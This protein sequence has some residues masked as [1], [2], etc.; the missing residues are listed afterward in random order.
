M[1]SNEQLATTASLELLCACG[2]WNSTLWSVRR[3]AD[4]L[5]ANLVLDVNTGVKKHRDCKLYINVEFFFF[6]SRH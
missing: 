1:G 6:L 4:F 5:A 3:Q 2:F